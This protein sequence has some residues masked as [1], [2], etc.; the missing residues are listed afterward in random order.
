MKAIVF[1]AALAFLIHPLPTVMDDSARPAA[2]LAQNCGGYGG[3]ECPGV[4]SESGHKNRDSSS[5]APSDRRSNVKDDCTKGGYG[6]ADCPGY[7][8]KSSSGASTTDEEAAKKLQGCG[9]Y[10]AND[11]PKANQPK[12]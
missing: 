5:E 7:S 8:S 4:A 12:Q 3:T 11:C 9:G 2:L 6:V 1:A 10:G